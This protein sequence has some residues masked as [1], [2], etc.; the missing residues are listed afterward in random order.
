MTHETWKAVS[1]NGV[2]VE[3][4]SLGRV[5]TKD[6]V[7]FSERA[8]KPFKQVRRGKILSPFIARNGYPTIAICVA[9]VRKKFTVHRL[10]AEAF[11]P[12][13]SPELTV[14]HINCVKTD[15]RAEN[16]EWVTLAR[17]TELQWRDGLVTLRGDNQPS[18]K[19]SARKVRIIR[20][21]L[22]L[23]ATRNEIAELSGVSFAAIDLISKGKRW[24][25]V[26]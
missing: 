5:R 20:R 12:G 19:L 24:A 10:V 26:S 22:V 13:Y 9:G 4:S 8:G 16:L 21:L 18:R 11:C 3:A 7:A 17:N 1:V 6:R 2:E 15:N 23:G 25:S 14:N